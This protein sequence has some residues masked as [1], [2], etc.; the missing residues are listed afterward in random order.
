MIKRITCFFYLSGFLL[1]LAGCNNGTDKNSASQHTDSLRRKE[2]TGNSPVLSPEASLHAIKAEDGFE[3]K[4]VAAEPLISTPVAMNFDEKGRIWVIEMQG[5]MPDT[6]GNGESIPDGKIVILEDKNGDGVADERKVFMDS[7]VLPRALCLVEDGILIAEPPRLWYVEIKNDLPAKKI[8]VDTA[9]TEGGN[10]EHQPNGLIRAMDNWIY[11]ANSTKRYRKK[12]DIWLTEKT[13][14]RG[15]WGISQDDYGRLYYNNNSQNL[16]GDYFLPGLGSGN[17]NQG[18]ISGYDIDIVED[19]RVY[20]ARPTPGV[21]RGYMKDILD[22][23]LRLVNFTAACGPVIYRSSL[24]SSDYY[25]NAFVA[26]PSA[27]LIKRNIL[28]ENGYVTIG[29]QAYKE[30]EFLTSTDERFRPVSLYDGPDGALY[31]TDMYRGIIQHITYI[32]GYLKKEIKE[33]SLS[34]PLNCGR[35]YKIVPAG[36]STAQVIMPQGPQELVK[37]LQSPDGWVRDKAQQ[38]LID[39]KLMTAVPQLKINL[40]QSGNPLTIIHSLWAL[41]GLGVLQ[42]ED[43]LPLLKHSNWKIRIQALTALSAVINK[44]NYKQYASVLQDIINSTDTLAAP[45]IAFSTNLIQP[46]SQVLSDELL[47]SLSKKFPENIYVADA[48]IS[49][50]KNREVLF[51]KKLIAINSDT[52]LNI[53]KRFIKIIA[54]I[55]NNKVNKDVAL[56]KKQFPKGVN[57][58]QSVC[59]TCH[60]ENGNGLSSLAPPLNHSDWVTGNKDKLI[61]IVLLGLTGPV[62]VDNKLYK[63]PEISGEMPGIGSNKDI[64]DEDIAQ[65]LSFIRKNWSN[66][67]ES[68]TTEEVAKIRKKLNGRK[69]PFTMNEL[70]DW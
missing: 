66:R 40:K 12:G 43:I 29:R 64:S 36:K 2:I 19:N 14:L 45:Y 27:N 6:A 42:E 13:H 1:F 52:S 69:E 33:R 34:N 25:N 15:Q 60:G 67:A 22:D 16:I 61:S 26:E 68:V 28:Q 21:N 46:F 23:S 4:L 65:V 49:N 63:A 48:I 44:T 8:I 10:V 9:Y 32:T 20:P 5:Y 56:L 70:N 3:V 41:E 35:I 55:N 57:L 11:S 62:R 54:D 17:P 51:Y 30:H 38:L 59:K 31:I 7:L 47:L 24:F 53:H 58:F 39:R 50:L 18:S 37:L